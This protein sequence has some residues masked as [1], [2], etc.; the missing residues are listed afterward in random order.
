M[1][2]CIFGVIAYLVGFYVFPYL[3]GSAN[4]SE[5]DK[6][7]KYI[8]ASIWP[9]MLLLFLILLPVYAVRKYKDLMK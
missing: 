9:L 8:A 5:S 7:N 2:N 4:E 3:I 6:K 1:T